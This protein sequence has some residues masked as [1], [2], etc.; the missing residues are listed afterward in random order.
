[1]AQP[2]AAK[3]LEAGRAPCRGR[4]LDFVLGAVGSHCCIWTEERQNQTV[5]CG[6]PEEAFDHTSED[7]PHG[8]QVSGS[9]VGSRGF[10]S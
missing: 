3:G 2:G 10:E 7:V 4:N 9:G 5:F 1:M 8:T 6:D